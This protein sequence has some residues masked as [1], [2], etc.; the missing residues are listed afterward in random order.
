MRGPDAISTGRARTLRRQSTRAETVLWRHLRGRQLAGCKFVRQEPIGPY[1][2]DFICRERHLVIEVDGG[3]HA[4][5]AADAER[6]AVLRGL[7]YRII[8]V[9]NNDVPLPA[10]GERDPGDAVR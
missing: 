2:V 5:N 9:W 4:E 10:C 7:G 6:D 8:R 3:Q 1:F